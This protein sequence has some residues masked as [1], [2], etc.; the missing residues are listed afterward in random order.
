MQLKFVVPKASANAEGMIVKKGCVKAEQTFRVQHQ[1]E[2]PGIYYQMTGHRGERER[3]RERET[4]LMR[5]QKDVTSG[6]P[7]T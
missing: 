1:Y 4:I 7:D 3:E 2:A 6:R 5:R